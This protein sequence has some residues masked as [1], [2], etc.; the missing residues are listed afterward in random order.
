[1]KLNWVETLV[2]NNPVR[3]GLQRRREGPGLR[4]LAPGPTEGAATL[5]VGCGRGVDVE[6][7]FELFKASTVTAIDLDERQVE[8]ARRRLGSRYGS[9]LEL[10]AC[11][12][13]E[14][15]FESGRFG[16]VLDFGIIHHIPEWKKA[17]AQISRVLT[18]GGQFLF[19]EI[20]K[21][22]LDTW[23][24]R[25]FTDHPREDRFNAPDFA[26]ACTEAGL[27]LG[28][29]IEPFRILVFNAFRGAAVKPE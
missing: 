8:R 5:V 20:P 26:Q 4:G 22:E 13:A 7:A 29:R 11:D 24:Y 27:D 25:F 23:V 12:A 17:V 10:I 14:L 21:S 19:E 28:G 9:A 3:A 6:I 1:M 16:L 2:M 18:P 15:P